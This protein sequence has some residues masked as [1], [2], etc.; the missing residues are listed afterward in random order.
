VAD[1]I[2]K[3]LPIVLAESLGEPICETLV[4]KPDPVP[5]ETRN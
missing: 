1:L 5:R 4:S 2:Q 3:A